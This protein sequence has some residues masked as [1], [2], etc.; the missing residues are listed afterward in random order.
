VAL[1]ISLVVLVGLYF[2]KTKLVM[3][4][5]IF[6]EGESSPPPAS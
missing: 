3:G 4:E 2:L 5:K 1:I 6:T